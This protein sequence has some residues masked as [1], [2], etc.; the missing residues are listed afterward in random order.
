MVAA[1]TVGTGPLR[2]YAAPT[3]REGGI[4][5]TGGVVLNGRLLFAVGNGESTSGYDQRLGARPDPGVD[6]GGQLQPRR[7]MTNLTARLCLLRQ[8]FATDREGR[9][10]YRRLERELAEYPAPVDRLDVESIVTRYSAA[11]ARSVRSSTVSTPYRG[12]GPEP[13]M[14]ADAP[15]P[16]G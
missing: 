5:A 1:P 14:V 8:A 2:N 9:A 7:Q 11:R 6:A 10:E 16:A 4:W 15:I 3:S 13:T 12:A